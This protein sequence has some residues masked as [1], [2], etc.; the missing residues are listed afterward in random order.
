[1]VGTPLTLYL[2]QEHLSLSRERIRHVSQYK[3]VAL[4]EPDEADVVWQLY[5]KQAPPQPASWLGR[6][7]AIMVNP[8]AHLMVGQSAGGVLLVSAH[9][10]LWGATFGTGHHAIDRSE[11][12]PDFGLRVAANRIDPQRVTMAETRGL[13]KGTRNAVSM[14]PLPSQIYGLRVAL[15]EE[16]VRRFGG[17]AVDRRFGISVAGAD[18]LRIS[19]DDF[20]LKQLPAKLAEILEA[21]RSEQYKEAFPF[22]DYFRRLPRQ[23]PLVP[24]LYEQLDERLRQ[25]DDLLG[26]AT[27]DDLQLYHPDDY[28]LKRGREE[29]SV[30]E[31]TAE[32][33][34][35]AIDSFDGWDNPRE[36]ITVT[37]RGGDL[38]EGKRHP[39]G[40]YLVANLTA[41]DD[42]Q[43]AE[44]ALTADAWFKIDQAYAERVDRFMTTVVDITDELQLPR[45]DDASLLSRQ[46]PGSYAEERYNRHVSDEHGYSLLDRRFYYGPAHSGQQVEVCDLMTPARQLICVKRLDGAESMVHLFEQATLSASMMR[47]D[48]YQKR[49]MTDLRACGGPDEFGENSDWTFVLAVATSRPGELANL[50]SFFGKVAL[51]NNSELISGRGFQVAIAKIERADATPEA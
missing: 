50:L 41:P 38:E 23:S 21:F 25:R 33:V 32:A 19:L 14:L 3:K 39:L 10:R 4:V 8:D 31:L 16:W 17:K 13:D 40:R 30:V 2:F 22:L 28:L 29:V 5:L 34:Y 24:V 26:F 20:N 42:G 36:R 15:N 48:E 45:W 27:P 37:P 12:E 44:F 47:D 9:G 18:S 1:M 51:M 7:Q 46:V 49:V 35:Q 6:L 11:Y 43:D